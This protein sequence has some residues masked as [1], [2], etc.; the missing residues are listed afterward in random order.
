VEAQRVP[1]RGIIQTD[2]FG[3]LSG[4]V[5]ALGYL[6][7]DRPDRVQSLATHQRRPRRAR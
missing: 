6:P 3:K 5:T 4:P 2:E 7:Q 1:T